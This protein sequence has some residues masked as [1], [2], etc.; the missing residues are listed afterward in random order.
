MYAK[1]IDKRILNSKQDV[2]DFKESIDKLSFKV[3]K[4]KKRLKK[5]KRQQQEKALAENEKE[6]KNYVKVMRDY[7]N[8]KMLILH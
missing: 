3:N 1:I 5:R 4:E 6:K 2:K 7:I 8:S